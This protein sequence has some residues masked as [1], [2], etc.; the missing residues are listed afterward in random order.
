MEHRAKE[1][2]MEVTGQDSSSKIPVHLFDK[3]LARLAAEDTGQD[4]LL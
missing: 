1:I 2:L 4:Q 3:V